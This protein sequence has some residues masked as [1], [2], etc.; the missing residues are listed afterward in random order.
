ME[1]DR[2]RERERAF[3]KVCSPLLQTSKLNL[4]STG[5]SKF[6][7]IWIWNAVLEYF[8]EKI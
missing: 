6:L 8:Q 3:L 1:I 4:K 5:G 7:K 2:E